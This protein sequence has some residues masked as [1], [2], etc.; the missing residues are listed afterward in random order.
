[1]PSFFISVGY[2]QRCQALRKWQILRAAPWASS[3][4][5]GNRA[6][7]AAGRDF[8]ETRMR[9]YELCVRHQACAKRGAPKPGRKTRHC[10]GGLRL[11]R[12]NVGG[13]AAA[14][15]ARGKEPSVAAKAEGKPALKGVLCLCKSMRFCI[16]RAGLMWRFYLKVSEFAKAQKVAGI[17]KQ[18][19]SF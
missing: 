17:R 1:M 18:M 14:L 15:L 2:T 19:H 7:P 11:C 3:L 16:Y 13:R 5:E 9:P 6:L 8:W 4:R 10:P 12:Q